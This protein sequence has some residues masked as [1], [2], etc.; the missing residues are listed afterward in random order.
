MG[1][2]GVMTICTR[3][4]CFFL[5]V[6]RDKNRARLSAASCAGGGCGLSYQHLTNERHKKIDACQF[7][8]YLRHLWHVDL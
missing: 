3:F 5:P 8:P 4:D 1:F 7:C 2:A 6:G